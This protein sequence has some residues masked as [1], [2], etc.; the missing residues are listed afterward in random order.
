MRRK[1]LRSYGEASGCVEGV[2]PEADAAITAVNE[3]TTCH[4][5]RVVEWLAS[6][7]REGAWH[8]QGDRHLE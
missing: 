5:A 3:P 6:L 8:P 4:V 7:Q 2:G 1:A